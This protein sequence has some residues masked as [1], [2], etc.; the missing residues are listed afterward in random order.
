VGTLLIFV[1][2]MAMVFLPRSTSVLISLF[3]FLRKGAAMSQVQNEKKEM[4]EQVKVV[5]YVLT[6]V[7]YIFFV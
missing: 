6:Y 1:F 3:K 5:M 4:S 2:F 7:S